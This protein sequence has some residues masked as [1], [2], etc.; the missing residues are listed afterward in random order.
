[1]YADDN[2]IG[3]WLSTYF[4]NQANTY[5]LK[6]FFKSSNKDGARYLLRPLNWQNYQSWDSMKSNL[7]AAG[8]G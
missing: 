5:L 2:S 7:C 8:E 1:M 6:R 3:K 4:Q